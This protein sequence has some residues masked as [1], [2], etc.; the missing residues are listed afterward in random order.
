MSPHSTP[1][2][3]RPQPDWL[4]PLLQ[5]LPP[6]QLEQLL[7]AAGC[8][9]QRLRKL[10]PATVLACALAYAAHPDQPWQNLWAHLHP[11]DPAP[12]CA[13][14]W[15]YAR[16][17]L[18]WPA[19]RELFLR[20]AP[21][22]AAGAG[23]RLLALDGTTLA[24]PASAANARAF[25]YAKNQCG[26]SGYPLLRLVT[27]ADLGSQGILDAALGRGRASEVPLARRLTAS[28]PA[29]SLVL[30]DR[31][32]FGYRLIAAVLGR[33]SQVLFRLKAGQ[34]RLPCE[35]R[36]ADGSYL[37][38]IWP[39]PRARRQGRDGLAVR[40]IEYDRH[41]AEGAGPGERQRLLTTVLDPAVLPA[42]EA[43]ATYP[44]RWGHEGMHR[45]LKETLLGG[46]AV[47]LRSRR[48]EL[49]RQEVYAL[50]AVHNLL[51]GLMGRAA[52]GAGQDPSRLSYRGCWRVL[53]RQLLVA[54]GEAG[55]W[56]EGLLQ[57]LSRQRLGPK[58]LRQYPRK[59][60]SP[61]CKWPRKKKRDRGGKR[62]PGHYTIIPPSVN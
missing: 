35:G 12:P 9:C 1:A 61:R 2:T 52:R 14:A 46:R 24:M 28:V 13:A 48:P 16:Q 33:G 15:H 17:R 56:H 47:P 60:K 30:A 21:P 51:R 20:L 58:R 41:E 57:R 44:W 53:R 59:V 8:R 37:S 29:G 38:R 3:P 54:V 50:L 7:R 6:P 45:D 27:L 4:Q 62:N 42:G 5:R 19:V 36:L 43:V 22:P 31:L 11:H 10:P 39:S 55:A 18:G 34:Y 23:L 26:N 49:V 25:G 32:F 40:V